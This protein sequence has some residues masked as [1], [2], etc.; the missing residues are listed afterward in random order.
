MLN[1]YFNTFNVICD[2]KR[3]MWIWN[4]LIST[5]NP[6]IP[7]SRILSWTQSMNPIAAEHA[8]LHKWN[9]Y[10]FIYTAIFKVKQLAEN[11]YTKPLLLVT[12][13]KKFCPLPLSL[14]YLRAAI[15]TRID[16]GFRV[17]RP[18]LYKT[19]FKSRPLQCLLLEMIKP[20]IIASSLFLLGAVQ[21]EKAHYRPPDSSLPLS[22]TP[23][24][25]LFS[26]QVFFLNSPPSSLSLSR[27]ASLGT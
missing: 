6:M 12:R 26:L 9:R 13:E 10:L 18:S 20:F 23:R 24:R 8:S 27:L 16:E 25:P 17:A 4:N 19:I 3:T 11:E 22:H 15:V 2:L 5:W 14:L 7:G 1:N 21:R